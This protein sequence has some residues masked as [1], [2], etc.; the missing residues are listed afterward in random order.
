MGAGDSAERVEQVCVAAD[1]HARLPGE[2][3][4]EDD[5]RRFVGSGAGHAFVEELHQFG[6]LADPIRSS[7]GI[8]AIITAGSVA[9]ALA[10]GVLAGD[11]V[12]HPVDRGARMWRLRR[13]P[14]TWGPRRR[15]VG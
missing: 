15:Y 10:A 7:Q 11:F 8:L 2:R 12:A 3:A 9:L 1:E 4:V 14:R 5:L 6:L 13:G